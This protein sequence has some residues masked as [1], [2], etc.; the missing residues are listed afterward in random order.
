MVQRYKELELPSGSLKPKAFSISALIIGKAKLIEPLMLCH[1]FPPEEPGQERSLWYFGYLF[2]KLK[3]LALNSYLQNAHLPSA[4]SVL[5]IYSRRKCPSLRGQGGDGLIVGRMS[6]ELS[7]NHDK[8]N[9]VLRKLKELLPRKSTRPAVATYRLERR[10]LRFGPYCCQLI[11]MIHYKPVQI[12]IDAPGLTEIFIDLIVRH[13][14]PRP[15]RLDRTL[16]LSCHLKV[17]VFFVLLPRRQANYDSILIVDR[18]KKMLRD[19]SVQ[20]NR[21]TRASGNNFRYYNSIPQSPRLSEGDSVFTFKFWFPR[22]YAF[23]LIARVFYKDI[24]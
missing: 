9:L 24:E 5:E 2:F 16:R 10:Q 15:P 12:T 8:S 20:I 22:L 18:L 11:K 1:V 19:E 13:G 3:S 21:C 17:L 14:P 4:T 7:R 6:R 23:E